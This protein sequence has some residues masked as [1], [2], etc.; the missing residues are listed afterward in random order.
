MRLVKAASF[1]LVL[2]LI[3]GLS[4]TGCSTHCNKNF[5]SAGGG[6]SG[7]GVQSS[8]VC[9]PGGSGTGG[10]I[11]AGSAAALVYY[12]PFSLNAAGVSSNG[13]IGALTG[14][15]SPTLSGSGADDMII[16]NKKFVY[17]PQAS[18]SMVEAFAINRSTGALTAITGS[19][20]TLSFSTDTIAADPQGNFLFVGDEVGNEIAS[21]QIDASTG[22][23]TPS[24][25][26]PLLVPGISSGDVFTVDGKGK[27]LYVGEQNPS[28]PVHAFSIGNSGQLT[29]I[30][31]SPFALPIATPHADS[32][33]NFLLGIPGYVD[34]GSSS[35]NLIHV[36]SID[37]NTGVPT[38]VPSSPF[39][40]TN[41]P[42]EFA[43]H[44]SG[45]FVY[46]MEVSSTGSAAAMEGFRMD[47]NT[48]ALTP[49]PGSPFTTLPTALQCK[50]DQ[51]GNEM[52]CATSFSGNFVGFSVDPNT[53]ALNNTGQPF[54]GGG[55]PFA[56]TD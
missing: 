42:L 3:A 50:F 26:S 55:I 33:G 18:S 37:P 41:A 38:E 7:G 16:V 49:L 13:T 29:Q 4:L 31:G 27:F 11:A 2:L 28:G 6:T 32:T 51:S 47:T 39:A 12:I 25:G 22:V 36:F 35:I 17:I 52:M 30:T 5:S 10:G 46:V 20:F 44:P 24:P 54:A 56:V 53:G 23:L 34:E 21:F 14:F 48:G 43:I 1:A 19:P 15:T 45:K 8:N 40:T 9:G